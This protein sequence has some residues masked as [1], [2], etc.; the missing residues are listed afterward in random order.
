M[1]L[2]GVLEARL[3]AMNFQMSP[4][5]QWACAC[6]VSQAVEMMLLTEREERCAEQHDYTTLLLAMRVRCICSP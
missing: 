5:C 1:L 2:T 4:S 3:I 6:R